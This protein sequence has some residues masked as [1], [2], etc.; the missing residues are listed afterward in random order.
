MSAFQ[1]IY[2]EKEYCYSQQSEFLDFVETLL[3][4]K[5]AFKIAVNNSS[6]EIIKELQRLCAALNIQLKIEN[7]S[8]PEAVAEVIKVIGATVIG[9]TQGGMYGFII[10][11]SLE[12]LKNQLGGEQALEQFLEQILGVD[13][14]I[15]GCGQV[16]LATTV[17]N[18]LISGVVSALTLRQVEVKIHFADN[19][20]NYEGLVFCF[21]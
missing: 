21:S 1:V 9:A 5:K 2:E 4:A 14:F 8:D 19:S 11:Q 15:P 7:G 16:V 12:V 10:G 17:A 13:I 20:K 18:A 3:R 6:E